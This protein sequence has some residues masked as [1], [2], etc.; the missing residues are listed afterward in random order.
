M[1][2]KRVSKNKVDDSWQHCC[3]WCHYFENGK[4]YNSDVVNQ[5]EESSYWGAIY[6]VAESGKLSGVI[7]ETL[8]DE[9][10]IKTFLFS[11]ESILD[12]WNISQKRK[13]EFEEHFRECWSEFADFKLKEALDE[14]VSISYQNE[15]D[16]LTWRSG[17]YVEITEPE[18][19]CC[20]YWR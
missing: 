14:Q 7:E 4:C 6:G 9:P 1:K 17:G 5:I 20:K 11:I 16:K 8:N 18:D 13:K 2:L 3:R 12:K 19:Y 10:L 15:V